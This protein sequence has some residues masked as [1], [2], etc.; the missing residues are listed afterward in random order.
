MNKCNVALM[1]FVFM[2]F[3]NVAQACDVPSNKKGTCAA[4]F[5]YI[6]DSPNHPDSGADDSIGSTDEVVDEIGVAHNISLAH[7]KATFYLEH[8]YLRPLTRAPP[9]SMV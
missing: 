3:I 2:S 7:V 4:D 1:L 5:E 8:R 9:K 6:A